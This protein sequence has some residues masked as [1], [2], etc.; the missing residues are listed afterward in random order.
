MVVRVAGNTKPAIRL[1]VGNGA[2]GQRTNASVNWS[3]VVTASCECQ[4]NRYLHGITA[5]ISL[6]AIPD[7]VLLIL[8]RG[9][10]RKD[11]SG[12]TCNVIPH[13]YKEFRQ[14]PQREKYPTAV[15]LIA[16]LIVM[17]MGLRNERNAQEAGCG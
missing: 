4:L 1:V 16:V 14:D 2:P 15:I 9:I 13:I 7:S 11:A 3:I 17:V 10:S 8:M 6:R 5:G 12:M